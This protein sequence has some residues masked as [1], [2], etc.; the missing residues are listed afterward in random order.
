MPAQAFVSHGIDAAVDAVQ[1]A[2]ADADRDRFGP[3][4]TIF[5]LVP[6]DHAVL[7]SGCI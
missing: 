7:T 3:Q 1:L 6:G 2:F 4:S 5:E